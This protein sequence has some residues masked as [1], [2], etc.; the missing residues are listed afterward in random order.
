MAH[1]RR[2]AESLAADLAALQEPSR[3]EL[4]PE[5]R[6]RKAKLDGMAEML[7]HR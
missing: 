6:E 1:G 4:V 5:W 7:L 2:E 3:G